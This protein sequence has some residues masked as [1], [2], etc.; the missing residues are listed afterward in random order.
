MP[1][2]GY[3]LSVL[4]GLKRERQAAAAEAGEKKA[5]QTLTTE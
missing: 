3:L 1:T 4:Q 5:K 2:C